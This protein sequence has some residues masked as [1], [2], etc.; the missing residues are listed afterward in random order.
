MA[1]IT[2]SELGRLYGS[3]GVRGSLQAWTVR[4]HLRSSILGLNGL[5][6]ELEIPGETRVIG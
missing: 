2:A 6:H 5:A 3:A 1:D 4:P